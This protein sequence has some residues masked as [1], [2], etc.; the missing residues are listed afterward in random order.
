MPTHAVVT[1][2]GARRW[3]SG[4]PWIY[5]S[6]VAVRPSTAAGAVLVRDQGG[7]SLSWAL[8]SPRSEM[9]LRLLETDPSVTIDAAWWHARLSQAIARRARLAEDASAYRL[10]HGEADGCPSLVCDKYD[11]W[12][13]VQLMSAGLESHRDDIIEALRDLVR[14]SGILA[15]SRRPDCR[16]RPG[17]CC[18]RARNTHLCSWRNDQKHT[19]RDHWRHDC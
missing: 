9:S 15:R 2:K 3:A 17:L 13:V 6:D 10:V 14:P 5:R 11:R 1:A 8:W 4:H 7:K 18:N 16:Q 12:L 19:R